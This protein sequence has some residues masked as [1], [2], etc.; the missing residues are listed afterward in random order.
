MRCCN[1]RKSRCATFTNMKNDNHIS[2]EL[3]A[4]YLEGNATLAE[5]Q[6]LLAAVKVDPTLREMMQILMESEEQSAVALYPMLSLAAENPNNLCAFFSELYVLRKRGVAIDDHALLQLAQDKQWVTE[7]GTPLHAIGQ[8]LASQGLMITRQ[9]DATIEDIL[10]ALNAENEVIVAI[11][12][13]KLYPNRPDPDDAP[14]HAMVVVNI[15]QKLDI[16]TLFEPEVYAT[17]DF[18]LSDFSKAW[19]ESRN[20]MVR[21]LRSAEDYEPHP[22]DLED[23]P[24]TDDLLELRE[25][26]AENAHE[27]WA[28]ARKAEGWTYG[29]VRND[30]LKQHPDMIPYS[31]LPDSEKEY[32]RL[33]AMNTIKL[34]KKLGW[35]IK[36]M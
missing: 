2:D 19:H 1:S 14:N 3:I 20:Y 34:L 9:Y 29:P 30:A 7:N 16:I 27:V 12:I 35:E 6:S 17:M 26:I 5:V 21:V 23:V 22:L 25:A 32:D 15:D 31:A 11:D 18:Q 8:L 4:S 28:A 33:M 24:L 10:H 13:E 36:K